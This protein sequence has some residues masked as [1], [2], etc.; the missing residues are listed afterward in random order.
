MPQ[1]K[2][3]NDHV[4]NFLLAD[5]CAFCGL[6]PED[7]QGE[8]N[9]YIDIDPVTGK[10][11]LKFNPD[12]EY[13]CGPFRP[14]LLRT[15]TSQIAGIENY[16]RDEY[17]HVAIRS[18]LIGLGVIVL[19]VQHTLD[20]WWM[21]FPLAPILYF[22]GVH[23]RRARDARKARAEVIDEIYSQGIERDNGNTDGSGPNPK[24]P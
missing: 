13:C 24:L 17:T 12:D 15:D 22:M 18:G 4:R 8:P 16:S 21:L 7:C 19:M 14:R 5:T 10:L 2:A 9:K 20:Q 1:P 6:F 23:T 11:D 3:S